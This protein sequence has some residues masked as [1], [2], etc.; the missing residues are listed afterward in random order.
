MGDGFRP[1]VEYASDL[2]GT[3]E[4]RH[5]RAAAARGDAVKQTE[6]IDQSSV[7]SSE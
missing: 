3:V 4:R 5:S 2:T 1:G 7:G 6:M